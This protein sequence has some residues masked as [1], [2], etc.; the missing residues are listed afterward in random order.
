LV[1]INP[2]TLTNSTIYEELERQRQHISHIF[3]MKTL[4]TYGSVGNTEGSLALCL[5][6]GDYFGAVGAIP[7]IGRFPTADEQAEVAVISD[8]L[9]RR[10]FAGIPDIIGRRIRL[11]SSDF[12]IIGVAR[13]EFILVEEPYSEW[14]AIVPSDAFARSQGNERWSPLQVIA[15]LKAGKHASEYEAQL[16]SLWP[17]FL[18]A[19]APATMTLDQWREISG[20]RAQVVPIPRGINYILILNGS[21]PPAIHIAFGLSLLIFLS[22]CLALVLLAIAR[23]IRNRRQVAILS[24][25]GG[26]RWRIQQPLFLETVIL[27]ILGCSLGLLVAFWWSGLGASFLPGGAGINWHV[28]MD[29][30]VIAL[31]MFMTLFIVGIITIVTAIFGFRGS[32][33]RIMHSIDPLSRTHVRM[34]TYMLAI[35]LAISVLLA[36]YALFF[37]AAF[38]RLIHVPFGFDPENLYVLTLLTKPPERSLPDNYFPGLLAQ[39]EQIAD[40]ES[41]TITTGRPPADFPIEYRQP[42]RT[43]D[44]R[45]T[46]ATV[47]SVSPAYFR[48]LNLPLLSGRDFSWS[49]RNAAIVNEA[50]LKKLYPN[51]DSLK[52][53][54]S[55]GKSSFPLQII[56]VSGDMTYF[57]PRFGTSSMVF[58][59]CAEELESLPG[60]TSILIRSKRNI[61][62]VRRAVQTLLEPSGV[63]YI[64]RAASQKTYLSSSMQTERMLATVAGIFGSLIVLLAGVEL[65]AFC[66]YL[67]T[68]RSKELA[69]RASVGAGSAQI[70][71]AL[72][73]EI[74]K[75]FGV[76]L[77]LAIIMI[78]AGGRIVTSQTGLIQP[79]GFTHLVFAAMIVACIAISAIV[80]PA[81]QALR[82]NLAKTLRVD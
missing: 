77:A 6:K 49:D 11:G 38:S 60:G 75:A 13:P 26:G 35:Q 40:V 53:T 54:I 24:A 81:M 67:L 47:V 57:G 34:R 48:T 74:V 66:S 5:F 65:Y 36:Q 18:R 17:S 58:V 21:L 62:D 3:G 59:P 8:S 68:M 50:L 70:T 29:G 23:S 31:A 39:I 15:R 72:V 64:S 37:M 12:E 27:S 19:T 7:Q 33:S 14:D 4:V 10:E 45:E 28:K 78:V 56:G 41:A 82:I 76:G 51:Q 71:A 25:L 22:G 80:I 2:I 73:K 46:Q 42:V 32:S 52:Y 61:E 69:I 44:G 9:W 55:Y 63:Y 1:A 16:N 79:P 30:H 20:R 43:N